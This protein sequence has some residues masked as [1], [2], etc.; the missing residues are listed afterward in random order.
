ML[1]LIGEDGKKT[2]INV[3]CFNECCAYH[4]HQLWLQFFLCIPNGLFFVNLI[5]L[6]MFMHGASVILLKNVFLKIYDWTIL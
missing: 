1:E 5:F 4:P 3:Y 2:R 6:N